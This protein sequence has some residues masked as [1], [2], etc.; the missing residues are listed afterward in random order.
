MKDDDGRRLFIDTS[1][2]YI[3][4]YDVTV[5]KLPDTNLQTSAQISALKSVLVEY[6]M[7]VPPPGPDSTGELDTTQVNATFTFG[8]NV[9]RSQVTDPSSSHSICVISHLIW[10]MSHSI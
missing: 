3:E 8:H 7:V 6:E 9:S 4:I 10:V 1:E 5:D 2:P